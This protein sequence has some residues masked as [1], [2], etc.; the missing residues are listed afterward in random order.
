MAAQEAFLKIKS[1]CLDYSYLISIYDSDLSLL[2]QNIDVQNTALRYQ[3]TCQ[4]N[5]RTW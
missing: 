5:L 1:T 3:H 4:L 2:E